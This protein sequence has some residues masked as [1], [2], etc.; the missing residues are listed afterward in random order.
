[1]G[2]PSA[3]LNTPMDPKDPKVHMTLQ[4]KLAE[5]MVKFYPKFYRKLFST[6]RK[7][8]IILYVEMQKTLDRILKSVLLFYL[9]LVGYLTRSVFKLKQGSYVFIISN[10]EYIFSFYRGSSCGYFFWKFVQ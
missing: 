8:R 5:L 10:L 9:N 3:F 2:I 7:V 1:M 6:D 4:R